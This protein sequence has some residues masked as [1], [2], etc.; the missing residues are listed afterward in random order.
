MEDVK[1]SYTDFHNL[2]ISKHNY[3]TE[4]VIRTVLG[5]YPKLKLDKSKYNGGSILDL[6]F[7]DGRNMQ[8]LD[9][10][11][12]N[13]SGIEITQQI[14]NSVA[15]LLK[16][17]NIN[18]DLRVGTNSNIPFTNNYFDYILASSSCYYVDGDSSF[19]D[20]IF[21]INRV[22]KP[23]GYLIA[24]FP[25]FSNVEGIEE[26]FILK[27]CE[28]RNDGHVLIR[29]DIYGL[30]NGYTFRAINNELDLKS[31]LEV[32]FDEICTG[33]LF[34]NYYGVQINSMICVARKKNG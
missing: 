16:S 23:G 9:N 5:E 31:E 10:C 18:A 15:E 2:K 26:S 33:K 20:N 7:G 29:N 27:D 12:L 21:E 28:F 3:P 14:C 30:R 11:G 19:K 13:V 17:R 6:G 34:D 32:Y 8:L 24:N 1:K 22:L 4:W 25:L